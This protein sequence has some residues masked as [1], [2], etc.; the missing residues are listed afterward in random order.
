MM[1]EHQAK[2]LEKLAKKGWLEKHEELAALG[3]NFPWR[4]L[5]M[6]KKFDGDVEKAK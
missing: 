5:H 4:N 6:L 1:Q 2:A 3:F